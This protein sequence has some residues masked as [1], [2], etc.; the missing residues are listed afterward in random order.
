MHACMLCQPCK[1]CIVLQGDSATITV[2]CIGSV[3]IYQMNFKV[4]PGTIMGKV[5]DALAEGCCGDGHLTI[6]FPRRGECFLVEDRHRFRELP[7]RPD[8]E[9][10]WTVPM[11]G[12]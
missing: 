10:Y 3:S 7:M 12:G 2:A 6:G 11:R 5:M 4:N 1:S 8:S 9:L